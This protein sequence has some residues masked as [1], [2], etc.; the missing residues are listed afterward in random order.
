MIAKKG[1]SLIEIVIGIL[2]LL[3]VIIPAYNLFSR[4]NKYMEQTQKLSLAHIVVRRVLESMLTTAREE[5]MDK[6]QAHAQFMPITPGTGGS[7]LSPYF[8]N[9][10]LSQS[11]MN[12]Q[13]F[14]NLS[15]ILKSYRVKVELLPAPDLETLDRVKLARVEVQ[16]EDLLTQRKQNLV[17]QSLVG[18]HHNL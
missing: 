18:N 4:S 13:Q 6:L 10:D 9:F 1:F 5:G 2:I 11:G 3:A 14:P 12:I 16:W 8:T 7:N 17:F 15:A